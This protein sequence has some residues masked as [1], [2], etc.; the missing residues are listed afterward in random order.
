MLKVLN[1]V[2]PKASPKLVLRVPNEKLLE[3]MIE[4]EER[5][6]TSKYY[7]DK[8]TQVKDIPNGWLDVTALVQTDIAK[9]HGFTD[10]MSCDIACN[11]MRRA[12]ILF[13]NNEKFKSVPLQ[14]R[15]NKANI[16]GLSAGDAL[17]NIELYDQGEVKISL[18]SLVDSSRPTVIFAGSQT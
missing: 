5:V 4:E 8:C 10:K 16:G 11:M 14:V 12:H 6:R 18:S 3:E 17:P 15:N 7:Q 13:P 9:S 1:G 2:P